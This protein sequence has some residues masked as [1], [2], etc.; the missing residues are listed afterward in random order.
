MWIANV[1]SGALLLVLGILI[2]A[3]NLSGLIAGYNT[4]SESEKARYNEKALIRAVGLTLVLA[5]SIL[6]AGGFLMLADIAPTVMVCVSWGLSVAILI[7]CAVYTNVSPRIKSR[8][9]QS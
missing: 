9:I 1:F 8:E 2:R 4:A 5:G 6:V 7:A 3:F